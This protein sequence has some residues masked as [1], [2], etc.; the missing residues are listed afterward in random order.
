MYAYNIISVFL[1]PEG[2]DRRNT[3]SANAVNRLPP[4]ILT[5]RVHLPKEPDLTLEGTIQRK[6]AL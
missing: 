1:A 4:F 2:H 3:V 6:C 5:S